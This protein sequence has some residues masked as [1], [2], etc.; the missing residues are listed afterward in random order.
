MSEVGT[1]GGEHH[2]VGGEGLSIAGQCDVDKVF[3]VPEM[4]KRRQ[5]GRLEVVPS[6]TVQLL[7]LVVVSAVTPMTPVT[8]VVQ[9]TPYDNVVVDHVLFAHV[10]HL[11]LRLRLLW[12]FYLL[13]LLL[14]LLVL[15][16]LLL[17]KLWKKLEN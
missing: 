2:L 12:L 16:L 10:A 9:L 4:P 15:L 7:V 8:P 3:F 6:Q 1:A 14:L 13:L 11:H 17:F 5:N